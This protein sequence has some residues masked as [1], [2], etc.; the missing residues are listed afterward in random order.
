MTA[1]PSAEALKEN[2]YLADCFWECYVLI[3]HNARGRRRDIATTI[4]AAKVIHHQKVII[5][6][7][8]ER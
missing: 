1:V 3:G 5:V 6:R 8:S 7:I 2:I 4:E